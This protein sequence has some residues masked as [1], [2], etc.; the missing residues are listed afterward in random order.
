M[1]PRK[2]FDR[3]TTSLVDF[4]TN[5]CDQTNRVLVADETECRWPWNAS[6]EQQNE[7]SDIHNRTRKEFDEKV[8]AL[9][10]E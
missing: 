4:R 5:P 9:R 10:D 8:R 6:A 2:L 3:L 1:I 7:W